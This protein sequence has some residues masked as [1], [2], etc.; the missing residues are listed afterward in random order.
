MADVS[1]GIIPIYLGALDAVRK[2]ASEEPESRFSGAILASF[3]TSSPAEN[4]FDIAI[5]GLRYFDSHPVALV[6]VLEFRFAARIGQ[7][8]GP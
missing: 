6:N 8:S 7:F 5:S 1:S 3:A 4:P 2:A